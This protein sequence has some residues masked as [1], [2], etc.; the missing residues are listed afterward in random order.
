MQVAS[1]EETHI[2]SPRFSTPSAPATRGRHSISIRRCWPRFRPAFPSSTGAG[3]AASS[4]TAASPPRATTA[5]SLPPGPIMPPAPG[6]GETSSP[7]P[8][9]LEISK[10]RH[11]I[12][13]GV[14]FQRLQDNEDYRLAPARPGE[15]CQPDHLPARHRDQFQV[16]PD[17]NE[18]G[19]RSLFGAWYFEDAIKLRPNLTLRA[20][21][22]HEW[23]TGWNEVS[24]RAANYVTDATGVLADRAAGR[25]FGFHRRTTPSCCSAPGS[26]WRGTHSETARPPSARDSEPIT[27]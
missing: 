27:P 15:L 8:T 10:G 9:T 13:A 4:S 26:A 2:F 17:P 14:W 23:S 25:R 7:I 18:L 3:R 11:Q 1:L 6:T 19:W 16:V 5:P 20:G 22:R 21:I 24:G 12:S